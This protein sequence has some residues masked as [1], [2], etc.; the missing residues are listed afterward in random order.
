MVNFKKY[1]DK[2][3]V[4]NLDKREDRFL[5]FK[6][7][8]E[9]FG[10]E[11]VERFSAIDGSTVTTNSKLL[12]GEIGVLMSHLEIVK[13]A[14]EQN[15]ENILIL[16]DDVFF[17]EEILKLD[18]YMNLVPND[19]DFIYFGGNHHYGPPPIILNDKIIKLNYTVALH[20]VG[21]NKT[22][23]DT[24]IAM[25]PKMGKQVDAYYADLHSLYN[26][27]GFKPNMAKQIAGFSDI[28]NRYVDYSGF[29][30]DEK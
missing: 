18:E 29:F 20:C 8:L 14:K 9:K 15:L 17:T 22:L 10:I 6:D 27:Y 24:I 30:R 2:I 13:Q 1:F 19:W 5:K 12:S 7:E 23:F 4:I 16:E 25:L 3:Y 26:A 28:Q 11:H 21:I